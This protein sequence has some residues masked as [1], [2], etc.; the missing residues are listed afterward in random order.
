MSANP[1]TAGFP[2][3]PMTDPSGNI[4][5]VWR[6]FFLALFNRTGGGAGASSAA[7]AAA[8]A[9]ETAARVAGD[10]SL[11]AAEAN[12]AA[13]RVAAIAAEAAA[14]ADTDAT[15]SRRI[16]TL[17]T[18]IGAGSGVTSLA[19]VPGMRARLWFGAA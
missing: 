4:T 1:F 6:S 11:S 8:L 16:A 3:A 2:S 5:P 17:A 10:Q 9:S 7:T 19:S 14:R 15:L 12:E 13:A 18:T